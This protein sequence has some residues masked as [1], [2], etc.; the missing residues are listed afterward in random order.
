MERNLKLVSIPDLVDR[1]EN[2]IRFGC[3]ST[4]AEA[5]RSLAGKELQKRTGGEVIA[6]LYARW[7]EMNKKTLSGVEESVRIGLGMLIQWIG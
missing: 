7:N 6:V 4:L 2:D 1:F 3:H 5:S